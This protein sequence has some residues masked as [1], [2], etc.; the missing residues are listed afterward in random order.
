KYI[1]VSAP[2]DP[3]WDLLLDFDGE[4]FVL[5]GGYW[6]KFEVRRVRRSRARP[7]GIAYS[8]TLHARRTARG[9]S[10]STMRTRPVARQAGGRA[11]TITAIRSVRC[12]H[13]PIEMPRCYTKISGGKFVLF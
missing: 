1:C 13:T 12:G 5:A 9:W 7:E 3:G 10:G 8:L 2:R 6:V 4:T 11:P